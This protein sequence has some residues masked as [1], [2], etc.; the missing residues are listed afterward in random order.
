[1]DE[2]VTS[3]EIDAPLEVVWDACMD[4]ELL[5]EWVTILVR[6]RGHS[7]GPLRKGYEMEQRL[8]LRGVPFNVSWELVQY[9]APTVAVWHG[10]AP[11]RAR[12]ETEYRLSAI[13]AGRTRFDYRN[14]FRPPL[15]PL[16]GLVGGA[17]VGGLPQREADASLARL[18]ALVESRAP[19]G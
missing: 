15:G 12:A 18:K 9:D 14:A 10:K 16:G 3:V 11:A 17:L 7:D 1:M 2:V 6:M 8:C 5:P 4:P 19:R 13:D